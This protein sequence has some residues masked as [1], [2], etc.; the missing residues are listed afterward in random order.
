M[1]KPILVAIGIPASLSASTVGGARL[2]INLRAAYFSFN[3]DPT[4]TLGG[5]SRNTDDLE[6][7]GTVGR[8]RPALDNEHVGGV[9]EDRATSF[10]VGVWAD[11]E[12]SSSIVQDDRPGS[13]SL[14]GLQRLHP[15]GRSRASSAPGSSSVG[16]CELVDGEVLRLSVLD[17]P[18]PVVFHQGGLRSQSSTEGL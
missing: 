1:K 4:S 15:E 14:I 5:F 6:T 17:L 3:L 7:K 2:L 9:D 10:G 13:P 8:F 11:V 18:E 12:D 16:L